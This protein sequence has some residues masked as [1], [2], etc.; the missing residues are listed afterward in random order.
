MLRSLADT[1]G[2]D[3]IKS[4]VLLAKHVTAVTM[5]PKT[6]GPHRRY[7]AEGAFRHFYYPGSLW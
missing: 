5:T 1:L 4:R 6:E 7:S 2:K 3:P